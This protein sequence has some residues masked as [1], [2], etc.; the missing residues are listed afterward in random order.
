MTAEKYTYS[1]NPRA[2]KAET[3]LRETIFLMLFI[4]VVS[5]VYLLAFFYAFN[6]TMEARDQSTCEWSKISGNT[7]AYR[8]YCHK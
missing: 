6:K 8:I 5:F 7:E 1:Y 3:G 4:T 2:K